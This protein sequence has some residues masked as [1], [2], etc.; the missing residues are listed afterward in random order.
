MYKTPY[1]VMCIFV[2]APYSSA[3]LSSMFKYRSV[4]MVLRG[5]KHVAVYEQV[6]TVD[7]YKGF[8]D[9][10]SFGV[11][12][13]RWN[14]LQAFHNIIPQ[15]FS[16]NNPS[17]HTA[18]ILRFTAFAT[19]LLFHFVLILKSETSVMVVCR[20]FKVTTV[21]SYWQSGRQGLYGRLRFSFSSFNSKRN[22]P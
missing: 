3:F 10:F 9:G 21:F 1:I 12:I 2:N 7:Y 13:T 4:S 14:Q 5:T 16:F 18:C 19:F 6:G 17:L 20:L 15:P 22:T 8:F 11:R